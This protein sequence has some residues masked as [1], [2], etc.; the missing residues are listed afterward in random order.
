MKHK[1]YDELIKMVAE[2]RLE[3]HNL[4]DDKLDKLVLRTFKIDRATLRD[5][6]GVT[7]L[8][9]QVENDPQ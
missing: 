3:H 9:S 5:I 8:I 4:T 1:T 7:D 2:F 6:D